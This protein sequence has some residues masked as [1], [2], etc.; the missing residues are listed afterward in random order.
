MMTRDLAA[1]VAETTA[2]PAAYYESL[3]LEAEETTEKLKRDASA[4]C[5]YVGQP[6][7]K[8]KRDVSKREA[9][10]EA[11]ARCGYVGQP[12]GK[13]RRAAEAVAEAVANAEPVARCGYVGQPCGKAKRD[14]LALAHAADLVLG[15]L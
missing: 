5:G 9:D 12:C 14:A 7:G 1:I 11:K 4:W 15:N 3:N 6:C 10:P 2:D 13:L 8:A